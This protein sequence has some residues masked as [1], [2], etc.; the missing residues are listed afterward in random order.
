MKKT[1]FV[2]IDTQNDFILDD[3]KLTVHG[4][5]LIPVFQR[6]NRF[7]EKNGIPLFSSM[8][9]H[10][11]DDPEFEEFGPHCVAGSEGQKK[12]EGTVLDNSKVFSYKSEV[13]T[14]W[15][16]ETEEHDQL[17][18]ET[19]KLSIFSNPN[20]ER[21][22]KELDVERFVVYGIATEYCVKEAVMG[23]LERGKNTYLATD[24]IRGISDED[25]KK[26]IDDM[27]KAGAVLTTTDELLSE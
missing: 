27:K 11:P 10:T 15:S 22:V 1:V 23:L 26:A 24:A 19:V 12:V 14:D 8:D 4:E 7:A 6:L 25:A 16:S 5:D 20:F 2:D 18:F 3:G 9:A 21:L 13:R 17:I